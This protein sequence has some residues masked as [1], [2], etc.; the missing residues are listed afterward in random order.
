MGFNG[1]KLVSL[2]FATVRILYESK[3]CAQFSTTFELKFI[4]ICIIYC[5]LVTSIFFFNFSK[6]S[7]KCTSFY[8][9]HPFSFCLVIKIDFH[10]VFFSVKIF[11]VNTTAKNKLNFTVM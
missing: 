11:P 1:E 9:N 5:C 7:F 10:N 4:S 2:R 3:L 6:F 8:L